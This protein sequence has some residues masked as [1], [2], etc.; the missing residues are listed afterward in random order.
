MN[1]RDE[2]LRF[3]RGLLYGIAFAI[4]LWAGIYLLTNWIITR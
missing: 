3:F 1:E 2:S 4:P